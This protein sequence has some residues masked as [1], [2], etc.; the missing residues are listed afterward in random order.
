M[1]DFATLRQRMVDNQ[2]RPSEVTN[3]LV[4]GAFLSV[5]RE[6]FVADDERPF[7]YAD[8]ELRMAASAPSRRMMDPARLARLVHALPLGPEAKALV[9]GCGS[10][11][12]AAILSYLAGAVIAVEEDRTLAEIARRR[13]SSLDVRNVTVIEAP[14]TGGWS[15]ATPYDAILIDGAVEFMPDT[16]V[17]QLAPG[18]F[19]ATIV[20][21]ERLSRAMLY[22]RV[23]EEAAKWPQFDAWATLLPGFERKREFLF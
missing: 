12:S 8:R 16:L 4:L 1:T 11:Y 20:R 17:R 15:D 23:H 22:E 6:I 14:L 3:H 13:L 10:G 5:P 7:A 19:L 21:E 9:V 2:I 18:A